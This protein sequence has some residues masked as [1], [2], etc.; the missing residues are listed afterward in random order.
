MIYFVNWRIGGI[1]VNN[2]IKSIYSLTPMQEGMLFHSLENKESNAYFVQA[3]I[4]L[5]GSI[6]ISILEKSFNKLIEKYD[7]LRTAI[8]YKNI[9]KPQQ[10]VLKERTAKLYYEDVSE[11]EDIAIDEYV[12]EFKENDRV[13]GFDLTKDNLIRLSMIKKEKDTYKLILSFHHILMDGWCTGIIFNDLM[14]N[15]DLLKRGQSIDTVEVYNYRNYIEWL[16]KQDKAEAMDYWLNQLAEYDTSASLPKLC[17][18]NKERVYLQE[19]IKCKLDEEITNIIK[20]LANQ[21]QVTLNTLF[22]TVWGVLLQKF[23]NTKEVVFGA[24]VSGRPSEVEGIEEM[25]GLFINTIPIKIDTKP[26]MSFKDLLVNVQNRALLNEKYSYFPLAEIQSMTE[27]KNNLL[28]H[29]LVFENYPFKEAD[30]EDEAKFEVNI[31]TLT[32]FEQTNYDLNI[33]VMPDNEL[34]I[35][36]DFNAA[37]YD[38][39]L[40]ELISKYF[41]SIVRDIMDNEDI[42]VRDITMIS[43]QEREKLLY[44][45]ND[46][47]SE[48]PKDKTL[49]Q[50]FE[51]Q[52]TNNPQQIAVKYEDK[53]LTYEQLNKRSNQLA[54]VFRN[55][56]VGVGKVVGLMVD[57]SLEMIVGILA[58]LKTGG[59]YLPIDPSFPKG[60]AA[61]MLEDSNASLLVGYKEFMCELDYS[62]KTIDIREQSLYQGDGSNIGQVNSSDDLAYVM[63]TS[64]T[65]GKAKGI[66]TTHYNIVRVVKKTNYI[67]IKPEDKLLQLSNFAF[68][69]S[70]FDIF[71]SLLNGASLLLLKE[72]EILEISK[73]AKI[74]Q[75]EKITVFFVTT[76][77]FNMIVTTKLEALKNVRKILFGGEQISVS[78]TAKALE[79][80]GEN[81]IIHV[82]GPTETTVYASYYHINEVNEER[83]TIPIGKPIANTRIYILDRDNNLQPIG[84]PG[85]LCITGDGLAKGYLNRPELTAEKFIDNPFGE[86]KLYK[87]GDLAR[88]LPGGNIEFLGRIDHQVKIRGFRI[89]TGEI[90]NQLLKHEEIKEAVVVVKKE[91]SG[92]SLV[93]YIV[94]EKELSVS[95]LRKYLAKELP[96]YMIPA[97][98]VAL[99][100][101]PLTS[102]GKINRK[103]LPEVDGKIDTG[104][105]YLAPGNDIEEKLVKIWEEVLGIE[106][107]GVNDN[108]FDLG[109][110]SLLVIKI[111]AQIDKLYPNKVKITDLFSLTTIKEMGEYIKNGRKDVANIELT[112]ASIPED[113]FVK[114]K[115]DEENSILSY[116]IK[117]DLLS[118][119]KLI[120]KIEKV[121][122]EVIFLVTYV[123]LLSKITAKNEIPIHLSLD[124]SNQVCDTS[125]I[126]ANIK[127]VSD[128]FVSVNQSIELGK[129][130]Y[131]GD[132]DKV[133]L[134]KKQFE[135]LS[136]FQIKPFINCNFT[137]TNVYDIVF[138]IN[139]NGDEIDLELQHSNRLSR[140][141][142]EKL[143]M[144]Y[145]KMLRVLVES[146]NI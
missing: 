133:I 129:K 100:K 77:M 18:K 66:L 74:I 84:A 81:K 144:S 16:E 44:D 94:S 54:R 143:F 110:H 122:I 128:L 134:E 25:V 49:Y 15:Y 46:T 115:F 22:Q 68:D 80:L 9:K 82:Y 59:A 111:H 93:G 2:N 50:L 72:E 30:F 106:K 85:E 8:V 90:E 137:L 31:N 45:F 113:Y 20:E 123:N 56:G 10:V 78:H 87:T 124:D 47:H 97:Y 125:V 69:G 4:E 71:G 5:K 117:K 3:S 103:A 141:K 105:E 83:E 32:V 12:K 121:K 101:I 139:N 132:M 107:V 98:F 58:I 91:E 53:S 138:A 24:V 118:N 76:A 96:E 36:Y 130:Y 27:L 95:A 104:V 75:E 7:I 43:K 88:W 116:D 127:S 60:R 21:N 33:I 48:Y 39:E 135:I 102:N 28:D 17:Y 55:N 41:M 131:I 99:D 6:D 42:K 112:F 35:R 52:V 79:Y 120:S 108:F 89:E 11:N 40:I 73:L 142:M 62:G 64:G 65:T 34:T 26:D 29:I 23:N 67:E 14:K 51:E 19:E 1:E 126:F 37:I 92:K 13:R 119:L 146:Y 63:Y 145:I 140:N 70:I 114:S 86:G 136:L 38:R 109:G 61:Y 57:R